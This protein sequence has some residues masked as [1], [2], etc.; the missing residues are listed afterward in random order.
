[1][2]WKLRSF[3][4]LTAAAL[5]YQS[6][7]LPAD[8]KAFLDP[9]DLIHLNSNNNTPRN[10]KNDLD[11]HQNGT[12]VRNGETHAWLDHI[13][14]FNSFVNPEA[15]R[16]MESWLQP[17]KHAHIERVEEISGS[18]SNYQSCAGEELSCKTST[19][20]KRIGYT[21]YRFGSAYKKGG[22]SLVLHHDTMALDL[23]KLRHVVETELK[24]RNIRWSVIRLDCGQNERGQSIEASTIKGTGWAVYPSPDTQDS[25]SCGTSKAI[26]WRDGKLKKMTKLLTML[27]GDDPEKIN[28]DCLLESREF[29][30]Y[31]LDSPGII[32]HS[33]Q[34]SPQPTPI[35]G[36]WDYGRIQQTSNQ[37]MENVHKKMPLAAEHEALAIRVDRILYVNLAKNKLRR[38]FMESWLSR[39]SIPYQRVN[40]MSSS[41]QADSCAFDKTK[42]VCRGIVGYDRTLVHTLESMADLQTGNTMILEDDMLPSDSR[43]DRLVQAI[44]IVPPD[45]ELVRFDCWGMEDFNFDWPNPF[46][47]ATNSYSIK[48]CDKVDT[49]NCHK[50][51]CGGSHSMVFSARGIGKLKR[52]W[53][54]KPYQ[55]ADC[56]IA[57]TPSLRSYCVNLGFWETIHIKSELS[58]I[59][60]L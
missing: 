56:I 46:V 36:T 11:F 4:L 13:Y 45:W 38:Q 26:L 59:S 6:L 54:T 37:N 18:T 60:G 49:K 22:V 32:Q 55:N 20:T 33:N 48:G 10:Q 57:R 50:T 25:E 28:I 3:L 39:H 5:L 14:Y 8:L 2:N 16:F 21:Y 31:C 15:E 17:I 23:E 34:L 40:A 53:S 19:E 58:D 44:K 52:M 29:G 1:M 24:K 27:H 9:E 51:F 12:S 30:S 47:A 35:F 43:L 7:K 41:V 42:E